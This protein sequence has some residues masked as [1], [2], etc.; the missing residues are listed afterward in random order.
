MKEEE[1]SPLKDGSCT[2]GKR[3]CSDADGLDTG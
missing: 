1:D 2:K 3:D